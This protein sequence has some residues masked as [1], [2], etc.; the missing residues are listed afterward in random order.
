MKRFALFAMLLGACFIN[1]GCAKEEPA[2]PTDQ[3]AAEKPA[4]PAAEQ[5]A[6]KP[7]E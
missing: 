5:P 4:E 2:K 3:P 6:E 7:A 1:F